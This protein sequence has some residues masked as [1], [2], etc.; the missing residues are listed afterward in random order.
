M[1]GSFIS[2]I[3]HAVGVTVGGAEVLRVAID[4]KSALA[5]ARRLR[6]AR[7]HV[8]FGVDGHCPLSCCR[9]MH[10]ARPNLASTARMNQPLDQLTRA[11]PKVIGPAGHA[12][13]DYGT[14]ATL[15]GLGMRL[16]DR[17][18]RASAFAFANAGM[19][20]LSS[21]M[22]N[23]PG[24]VVRAMSFKTHG[25]VDVMQ[26]GMLAAG[27]ALLGFAGTQEARLFYGQAALE[28]AV[29]SATDWNALPSNA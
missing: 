28:L 25:L 12:V 15:M 11:V 5:R 29:V 24:G 26:A 13:A 18:S 23:Y 2:D 6:G 3:T 8:V 19:V 20:M 27:P 9:L 22:T 21:L 10:D 4:L 7:F 17:N 1:R 14:V 16:R